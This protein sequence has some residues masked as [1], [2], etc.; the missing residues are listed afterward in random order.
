MSQKASLRFY[1]QLP[2][3]EDVTSQ[4]LEG[5]GKE[6]KAIPP[7]FFY[8]ERGSELFTE[9]TRQP[10]YYPT[11]TEINLLKD[12][13]QTLKQLIGSEVVLI[14]YGSGSSEK[15][16]L[17]LETLRP[18]AYA[19]LDISREYLA[20]AAEEIDREYPWLAVHAA[21][22]DYTHDFHLP[23]QLPGRKVG[24]FPGSSIGNFTPADAAEFL[25]KVNKQLGSDGALL[26]G[27]D[28]KKDE[29]VLHRAYNDRAGVT[30]AFNLN[31]LEHLNRVYDATFDLDAFEHMARYDPVQGCIQMFLVSQRDQAVS[32]C[33]EQIELV[34]GERIHTENSYKYARAEFE[35]MTSAAGFVNQKVWQDPDGWFSIFYLHA[36]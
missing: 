33:G 16:R 5:L 12:L 22:I 23:F 24:F 11:R 13:R 30:A 21:C 10:E 4:L 1:D 2:E 9:I 7:K 29:A 19:P 26:I 36:S 32:V 27:V 17:L 25:S 31:V 14:E 34:K 35:A 6:Q 20:R 28:M 18:S 15:I 3:P 8:D